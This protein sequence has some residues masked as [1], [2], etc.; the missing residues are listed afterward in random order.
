MISVV[1]K[2]HYV[3]Q[4]YLKAWTIDGKI[5]CKRNNLQFNT[6]TEN[7]AQE[8]YFYEAKPLSSEEI[9]L[10]CRLIEGFHPS[11]H[12]L[13]KSTFKV[14]LE[15]SQGDKH[16]RRNG[17]EKFHSIV[18]GKVV[19]IIDELRESNLDTLTDD[20]NRVDFCHFL[21]R[22]Y[23]RTKKI[24]EKTIEIPD[25]I[26]V[27]EPFKTCDFKK[28]S[29]VMSFLLADNIGNWIHSN[30]KINLLVNNTNIN[31]IT[32]DQPIYNLLAK[33]NEEPTEFELYYPISPK[34]ALLISKH[35]KDIILKT[36]KTVIKLNNYIKQIAYESIFT[37]TKELLS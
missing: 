35:P 30:A 25:T 24:R 4:H 37:D 3:W 26:T 17:L 28:V 22:Q 34:L 29:E 19:P 20:Q 13:I 14:Y 11:A 8:R 23:T 32:G 10:I 31:F 18:E 6:S 12:P 1:K 16:L 36:E 15:I 2:Q 9:T 33:D 7:I 21:G 5:W 27:P